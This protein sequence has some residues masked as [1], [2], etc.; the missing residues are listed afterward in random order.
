MAS[1]I[2]ARVPRR[3]R[4]LT[5]VVI[6]VAAAVAPGIARAAALSPVAATSTAAAWS[7][8]TA[9]AIY[10][11]GIYRVDNDLFAG[12]KGPSC[13]RSS[14]G[15]DITI[16]SSYKAQ[17]P[18]VV[19]YPRV[20]VGVNYA[21]GDADA[22]L[23]LRVTQLGK[24]IL[25][26]KSTGSTSGNWLTDSDDW[27]FPTSNVSG[28]GNAEVVIG[29]RYSRWA[30][31]KGY[32][33]ISIGGHWYWALHAPTCEPGTKLCW[34]LTRLRA[35]APPNSGRKTAQ[36]TARSLRIG[37]FFWH[38]RKLHWLAS[39]EWLGSVAFGTECWSGCKNLTDSMTVSGLGS[40]S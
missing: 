33:R 2:T 22:R 19:A 29:L 5:I 1:R 8:C 20:Y 32:K 10:Y 25:R 14:D 3:G 7:T 28:H 16:R 39:S 6:A 27:L 24:V 23:P 30:P 18:S 13:V 40:T 31:G 34:E 36:I 37:T 21:S 9:R 12:K 17:G 38:L 4:M 35:A 15:H 11:D 26:V